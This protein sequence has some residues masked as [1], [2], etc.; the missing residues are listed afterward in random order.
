M[1]KHASRILLALITHSLFFSVCHAAQN[2][3]FNLLVSSDSESEDTFNIINKQHKKENVLAKD[4]LEP[5][6]TRIQVMHNEKTIFHHIMNPLGQKPRDLLDKNK[7]TQT[8]LST[9]PSLEDKKINTVDLKNFIHLISE[10]KIQK[11]GFKNYQDFTEALVTFHN[12]NGFDNWFRRV[13][14]DGIYFSVKTDAELQ[15]NIRNF[16]ASEQRTKCV[17]GHIYEL[18]VASK[19]VRLCR[20]LNIDYNAIQLSVIT[21]ESNKKYLEW[22]IAV[23]PLLIEVKN[24]VQVPQ[25]I[26][27]GKKVDESFAKRQKEGEE[28]IYKDT[29][30]IQYSASKVPEDCR[31]IL[32]SG[33]ELDKEFEVFLKENNIA[34]AELIIG[35]DVDGTA[36]NKLM[37]PALNH[38]KKELSEFS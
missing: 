20:E 30:S 34:Y 10:Q 31:F 2:N 32:I 3:M 27:F 25:K 4:I 9:L 1:K 29:E 16:P 12:N 7:V 15:K 13:V 33:Q 18:F 26:G 19:I 23:G 28:T 24:T 21:K 8:L 14:A 22:D 35:N 36:F 37:K 5:L 17:H 11:G 38:I 6:A